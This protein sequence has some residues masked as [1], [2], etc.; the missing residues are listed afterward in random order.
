VLLGIDLGTGSA[1]AVLIDTTGEMVASASAPCLVQSPEL[2]WAESDPAQW[3]C[4]V[5]RA[6]GEVVGAGSGPVRTLGREGSSIAAV[7]I[8][9]Q[10]HGAVLVDEC[11]RPV[12]PAILWADE[13]AVGMT[14]SYRRL[15]DTRRRSLANPAV[16][17]MTGPIL[18][19]LAEHEPALYHQARWVLQAK[20]W[21]RAEMVGGIGAEP[22][23]ASGTLLYDLQG[24]DWAYDVVDDLGLRRDVLA[25]LARSD[26]IAGLLT[27]R[28]AHHLGLAS[29]TEVVYG[30]AD[31]AAALVGSSLTEMGAI[32]LSV[33]SG[34]QV[35]TLRRKADPDAGGRYHVFSRATG[36]YYALAA[37]QAAGLAFEWAWSTLGCGWDAAYRALE[38]APPGSNGAMFVPHVA[39]ARSPSMNPAATAAFAGLRVGND[40][41]DLL[42]S[43]FEGVAFSIL[44][45]ASSLAE[46]QAA[47]EIRLAGGGSVVPAWRQLL[48]DVLDRPLIVLGD[49]NASA[50]GAAILAGVACGVSGAHMAPR[51]KSVTVVPHPER[52]RCLKDAFLRWRDTVYH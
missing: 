44:D 32:Q 35:V 8:C 3:W 50:R 25:P 51:R 16:P 19:W 1:K 52:A 9:G 39:G 41:S 21:L 6:V 48:A 40:R 46:Y 7:G 43:V 33:G 45:A 12:R 30:A 28:A 27:E 26:Q 2:G 15:D 22:S 10:M 42:R 37:V 14:E 49:E 34:A 4:A 36:G 20:D 17:G 24:H 29:G 23:D 5:G 38:L 18:C 31:T 47:G 11:H 13:R